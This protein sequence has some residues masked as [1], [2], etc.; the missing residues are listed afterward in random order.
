MILNRAVSALYRQ[1]LIK[2]DPVAYARRLGVT[3]GPGCWFP[4]FQAETFG[5]EPYLV[6]LGRRVAVASG[7]QFVTH[8]GGPWVLR[9]EFPDVDVVAPIT[10]GDDVM[11]G[12]RAIVMPGVT[13][14][15][16][17]VVG[18]GSVVTKDVPDGVV[19]AGVPAR[20]ICDLDDYRTRVLAKAIHTGT[21]PPAAKRAVLREKFARQPTR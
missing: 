3:V 9:E 11:L 7:V 6:S 17:V 21:L 19:V 14:G 10:V 15:S 8:D 13:I 2:R 5:S 18:A 20:V 12:S 1:Y 4:G 16:Q